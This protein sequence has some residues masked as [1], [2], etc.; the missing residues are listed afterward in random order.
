MTVSQ[1]AQAT[2]AVLTDGTAQIQLAGRSHGITGADV[3]D[4]RTLMLQLL[5]QRAAETGAPLTVD[6]TDPD[7]HFMLQVLPDGRIQTQ[8]NEPTPAEPPAPAAPAPT[9]AAAGPLTQQPDGESPLTRR[10]LRQSFLTVEQVEPP[11]TKGWRGRLTRLGVRTEPSA[12]ERAERDDVHAVSQHWPGVR[13]IAVV[14]GKGGSS[15]SPTTALLAATFAR[16]SGAATIAWDNNE[17][18]GTLGWRTEQGKHD[19]TVL[20][21]I[22]RAAELLN[23]A[24][25]AGDIS[26]F[27]HHQATDKY[28]VL[29]SNPNLLAS[30]QRITAADVD[31]VHNVLGRYYRL[32]LV[33]SGND[34]SA[35]HWLRMVD[36]ADQ[37]VVPTI[38]KPEH[39]EAGALLLEALTS[40]GG[41]SAELARGAVVIVSQAREKDVNPSAAEIAQGFHG[42]VRDVVTVPYDRAMVENVLHYDALAPSTQRAWLAAA[43][44]V[45]RQL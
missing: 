13:T 38:A 39:A 31:A 37:L 18:R 7:G 12:A 44:A 21:L 34:E 36:K 19:H 9:N 45:A 2:A 43:A 22:P 4:A 28:D 40:R 11:A 15:K 25:R 42:W 14:N 1:Q 10:Q 35:G 20:D 17:T 24:A 30:E 8:P 3:A 32:I 23:P 26:Q 6:V 29:R 27:V 5:V 16:Y 33:D 41:R